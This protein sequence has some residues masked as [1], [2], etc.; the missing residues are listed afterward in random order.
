M[1]LFLISFHVALPCAHFRAL[2]RTFSPLFSLIPTLVHLFSLYFA[3]LSAYFR[4]Y[5]LTQ[6]YLAISI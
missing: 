2:F 5:L 3:F 1:Y 4:I 6:A